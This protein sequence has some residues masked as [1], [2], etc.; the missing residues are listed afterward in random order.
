MGLRP[1]EFGASQP[2]FLFVSVP[3]LWSN[4]GQSICGLVPA[5]RTSMDC[6]P[7]GEAK[8]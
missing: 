1:V 6:G 2:F 5:D 8:G 3:G 7:S 4:K